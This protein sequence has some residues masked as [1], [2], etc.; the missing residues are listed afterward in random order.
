MFKRLN[1]CSFS[2]LAYPMT[3]TN[4]IETLQKQVD[5]VK[6]DL[7]NLKAETSEENKKNKAEAIS[8]TSKNLKAEI[9]S[10]LVE[11]KKDV[12]KNKNDIQKLEE[13]KKSLEGF[14]QELG[15]LKSQVENKKDKEINSAPTLWASIVYGGLIAKGLWSLPLIGESLKS[16]GEKKVK[17]SAEEKEKEKKE[18]KEKK[19]FWGKTWRFIRN[20]AL[21]AGAV[22]LG[23]KAIEYFTDK[24]KKNSQDQETPSTENGQNTENSQNTPSATTE[25]AQENPE[26]ISKEEAISDVNKY[27]LTWPDANGKYTPMEWYIRVDLTDTTNFAVKED[28]RE[29]P[30]DAF[31]NTIQ[32]VEDESQ[33]PKQRRSDK[34]VYYINYPSGNMKCKFFG[35]GR[36]VIY[37]D[38]NE[39]IGKMGNRSVDQNNA[40]VYVADT[41]ISETSNESNESDGEEVPTDDNQANQKA[42]KMAQE[43]Y[44]DVFILMRLYELWFVPKFNF[45]KRR[46]STVEW[47]ISYVAEWWPFTKGLDK[48]WEIR[49]NFKSRLL[50]SINLTKE[51]VTRMKLAAIKNKS[52][53]SILKNFDNEAKNLI[54]MYDDIEKWKITTFKE[55]KKKYGTDII[56]SRRGFGNAKKKIEVKYGKLDSIEKDVR[57]IDENIKKIKA[58]AA[59]KLKSFDYQAKRVQKNPKKLKEIQTKANAM[60]GEYNKQIIELEKQTGIK[61]SHLNATEIARLAKWSET[62]S[63]IVKLNNGI[64][65]YLAGNKM[66]KFMIGWT[67]IMLLSK[68]VEWATNETWKQVWLETADLWT[69]LVPFAW[70]IYDITTSITWKWFAWNLSTTDRIIRGSVGAV[71]L[72]LDV[73]W[74]FTFGAGNAASAWVKTLSRAG[75]ATAKTVKI[76]KAAKVVS[77]VGSTAMKVWTYGFLWYSA[78]EISKP[79]VVEWYQRVDKKSEA[80]VPLTIK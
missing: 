28:T 8:D 16:R 55:F 52:A 25:N 29:N 63:K 13:L 75:I 80:D 61:M 27:H 49:G 31:G 1:V 37:E 24:T 48:L 41:D 33:I 42:E 78:Y 47:K 34:I 74:L 62:V 76:V 14:D 79:Y 7:E 57:I 2:Y 58:E 53:P 10:T 32:K 70:W 35:N 56:K 9:E 71:S 45:E 23:K 54:N 39:S 68:W 46:G 11:L 20:T 50:G 30:Q 67:V 22:V 38:S 69:G 51:G 36:Y 18:P 60:I 12:E 3:P 26:F 6:I 4:N 44:S 43:W 64:D 73:A 77:E 65:K 59:K 19:W 15:D 66:G 40:I 72:V 21:I 5:Q 17:E